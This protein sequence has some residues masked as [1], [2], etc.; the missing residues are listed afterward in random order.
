MVFVILGTQDKTFERLLK[1]VD[2]L[3][4]AGVIKEHVVVQA[5][6]TSYQSDNMEIYD[7]LS[8]DEMHD[9][10]K[11]A[12]YI[13][14]HGGVGSIIEALKLN[15]K[16]IAVPRL[17]D[18]EEHTNNHQQEIVAKFSELGYVLDGSLLKDAISKLTK[19][20]P[21][22]YVSNTDNFVKIITDYIDSN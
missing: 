8:P 19:F 21:K 9:N 12:K 22:Q 13:I 11:K 17:K 10:M 5:G 4:I 14:T 3:I 7:F 16:I 2:D 6:N 1:E 18:Y 20:K 15:K